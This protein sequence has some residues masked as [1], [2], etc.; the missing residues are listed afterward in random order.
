MGKGSG[1]GGARGGGGGGGKITNEQEFAAKDLKTGRDRIG[2]PARFN[3]KVFDYADGVAKSLKPG[4][5]VLVEKTLKDGTTRSTTLTAVE[6]SQTW[7][8]G[9]TSK[10]LGVNVKGSTDGLSFSSNKD[11]PFDFFGRSGSQN[12]GDL[13]DFICA[14]RSKVKTVKVKVRRS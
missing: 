6:T 11:A 12:G 7:R 14:N 3:D 4:D 5:S 13:A 8:N 9:T 10:G 1:A 2:E